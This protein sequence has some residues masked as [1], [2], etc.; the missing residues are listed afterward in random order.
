MQKYGP[1]ASTSGN[2]GSYQ[3]SV[4]TASS[5]YGNA[6]NVNFRTPQAGDFVIDQYG[7]IGVIETYSTEVQTSYAVRLV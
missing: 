5:S 2:S 6:G 1:T 7:C 4:S 3:V